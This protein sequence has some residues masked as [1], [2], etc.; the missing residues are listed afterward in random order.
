MSGIP[1]KDVIPHTGFI[2]RYLRHYGLQPALPIGC[3]FTAA[4]T[5]AKAVNE[6]ASRPPAQAMPRRQSTRHNGSSSVQK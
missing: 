6:S 4:S 3:Y 2:G 1:R 5:V